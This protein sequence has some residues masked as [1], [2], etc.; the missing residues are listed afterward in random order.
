MLA[1]GT[2][3]FP[4]K[5]TVS[6]ITPRRTGLCAVTHIG[7]TI[8]AL[9]YTQRNTTHAAGRKDHR[10]R[11][12][13]GAARSIRAARSSC[14]TDW[15][16]PTRWLCESESRIRS[17]WPGTWRRPRPRTN[18][19]ER[20]RFTRCRLHPGRARNEATGGFGARRQ[21]RQAAQAQ[22]RLIAD[23]NCGRSRSVP[24]QS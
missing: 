1:F 13:C 5:L 17:A 2:S 4:R 20:S 8:C 12:L 9:G 7:G 10:R 16:Y 22:A 15:F 11:V 14:S 6:S 24:P 3:A 21:D 18:P 19:S 23:R